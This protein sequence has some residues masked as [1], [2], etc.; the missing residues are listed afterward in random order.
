MSHNKLTR[1]AMFLPA[2]RLQLGCLITLLVAVGCGESEH[3]TR[4]GVPKAPQTPVAPAAQADRDEVSSFQTTP[5][6]AWFLKLTGPTEAVATV[7]NDF[8]SLLSS[9]SIT[10]GSPT[11]KLPAG[12]T[13]QTGTGMRHAT[14]TIDKSDPPLEVSVIKL[15]YPGDRDAYLLDNINRWRGQIGLSPLSGPDWQTTA[16]AAGE[17]RPLDVASQD[18]TLVDLKGQTAEFPDARMLAAIL[19]PATP[20]APSTQTPEPMTPPTAGNPPAADGPLTYDIPEGWQPG[21]TSVMRVAAFDV[22]D[23]DQKVEITVIAAGGNVL[24]NVNRWRGQV[25]LEPWTV[26][27][28]QQNSEILTVDGQPATYVNLAG[29][30]QTILAAILP[31]EPQSWFFKLS[32]NPDLA[33]REAE[34]FKAFVESAKLK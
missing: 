27:Q 8:D 1:L 14:L 26:D 21:R 2:V 10:G 19:L 11:W 5:A 15:P 6:F 28:L 20:S 29:P 3:I 25:M 34:R 13:E 18:T 32:G 33:R 24:D 23:G 16:A 30:E 22:A 9:T 12:W 4:Y 7:T 17:V 31:G